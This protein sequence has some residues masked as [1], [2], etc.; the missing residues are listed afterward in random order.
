VSKV[1]ATTLSPGDRVLFQAGQTFIGELD[2]RGSGASGA[3]TVYGSYGG[4]QAIISAAPATYPTGVSYVTYSGLVLD[5][6]GAGDCVRTYSGSAA[7]HITFDGVELRNCVFGINQSRASDAN[8][9]VQNSYIH[10]TSDS[11]IVITGPSHSANGGGFVIQNN[12]IENTGMSTAAPP[13]GNDAHG[14]YDDSPGSQVIGNDIG[15]FQTDGISLR[16]RNSTVMNNTI[17]DGRRTTCCAVGVAYYNYDVTE[18]PGGGTSTVSFNRIWGVPYGVLVSGE[19]NNGAAN[20]PEN[21]QIYNNTISGSAG[22]SGALRNLISYASSTTGTSLVLQNNI[23]AGNSS[24]QLYLGRRPATYV[25]DHNDWAASGGGSGSG[26]ADMTANPQLSAAP[27]FTPASSSPVIGAGTSN[28]V[29]AS[30]AAACDMQASCSSTPNLGAVQSGVSP[31]PTPAPVATAP[32]TPSGVK[33]TGAD[34]NVVVMWSANPTGDGVTHYSVYRT[35]RTPGALATSSGTTFSD[36]SVADGT[37]YCYQ[38]TAT[39]AGGESPPSAPVC[40]TPTA[41]PTPTPTPTP[42]PPVPSMP[43]GLTAAA[44]NGYVVLTWNPNPASDAVVRYNAYRI[45]QSYQGPWASVTTTTF[46]NR[47]EVVNGTRYCYQVSATN[48][49]GESAK[50]TQ[51]CATPSA[52]VQGVPS[53]PTNLV[54]T[55][56]NGYVTLTWAANPAADAVTRYNVWRIGQTYTTPWASVTTTTFTNRGQVVNG[57]RYCY[58][59]TATNAA[60]DSTK[61]G[62]VCATPSSSIVAAKIVHTAAPKRP[63][64]VSHRRHHR[65]RHRPAKAGRA[66]RHRA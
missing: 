63:R 42:T 4:G 13:S 57:T 52:P 30:V 1:D 11:G 47:A 18:S 60:G 40:A 66:G 19:G 27:D 54:A 24:G 37:Q 61:S 9:R 53:A 36:S 12:R 58:Q 55:P 26:F 41:P 64:K 35:D 32:A 59:L 2:P 39:N 48:A 5:A 6:G 34:T 8:W 16:Y 33:A 31:P 7:T 51:A 17:H 10:D 65:R 50:S 43:A 44:G 22:A 23:F 25:E 62:P 56:G 3:P 49:A 38:I 14:I 21:W 45:G 28:I 15:G 20:G 46:T 29:G